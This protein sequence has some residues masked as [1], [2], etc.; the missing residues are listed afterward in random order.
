MSLIL[1]QS[2]TSPAATDVFVLNVFVPRF[3][4]C[5]WLDFECFSCPDF[6]CFCPVTV[7]PFSSESLSL[8]LSTPSLA[9]AKIG[10]V[11]N[12]NLH[13]T[14]QAG[15]FLTLTLS[16]TQA[17][18]VGL[19]LLISRL[20]CCFA[21][22]LPLLSLQILTDK[23]TDSKFIDFKFLWPIACPVQICPKN[24][25]LN[26]TEE[27]AFVLKAFGIKTNVKSSWAPWIR[28]EIESNLRPQST[29]EV[30]LFWLGTQTKLR[31]PQLSDWLWA[32]PQGGKATRQ[33]DRD[34]W[35]YVF[36]AVIS[37]NFDFVVSG[38]V[39]VFISYLFIFCC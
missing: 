2:G 7:F 6:Q 3:L 22:E 34:N 38:V 23:V 19:F 16:N 28:K 33:S 31:A 12:C 14:A 1:R 29:Y 18:E 20:R 10:C 9:R 36:A 17:F 24:C 4:W 27:G 32:K 35:I 25:K 37:V 15:P 8:F 21:E 26:A 30:Y 39:V 11:C 5:F 13:H